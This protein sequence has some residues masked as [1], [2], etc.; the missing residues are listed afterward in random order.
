MIRKIQCLD[1]FRSIELLPTP[2]ADVANGWNRR[3]VPLDVSN[4]CRCD[5]CNAVIPAGA[6]ARAVTNW[7]ENWEGEPLAW[8]EYYG[9]VS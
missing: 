2:T 1:C 8:E 6:E 7:N 9:R 5:L 4:E 3:V